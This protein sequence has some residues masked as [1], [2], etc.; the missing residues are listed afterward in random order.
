MTV[1]HMRFRVTALHA[2]VPEGIPI[3]WMGNRWPSGPLMIELDEGPG[4]EES[5]G[6]LD[7]V[8][9]YAQAEFHVR[10]EM[11]ELADLLQTLGVDPALT[12]PVYAVVRSQGKILH[13]HSFSLVGACRMEPHRLFDG[14]QAG[15][16]AGQ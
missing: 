16:L 5:R 7:Y 14:A 6:E 12:K 8:R 13:D 15:M 3:E 9:R 11:P 10:V 4:V 1:E 2:S